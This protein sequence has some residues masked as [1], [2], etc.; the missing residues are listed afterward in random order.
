MGRRRS[1]RKAGALL[2][3]DGCAG[4]VGCRSE[5]EVSGGALTVRTMGVTPAAAGTLAGA[6]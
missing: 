3:E 4:L 5:D 2:R 6:E 1:A